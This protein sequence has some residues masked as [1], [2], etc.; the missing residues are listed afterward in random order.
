[1]LWPLLQLTP[2]GD[3]HAVIVLPG[4][5]AGDMSTLVMRQFLRSRGYGARGWGRGMNAGFRDNALEAV[6]SV[7]RELRAS[8]GRRVSLIG[9]SLG[10]TFARALASEHP[11]LVRGVIT[12]GTQYHG[13]PAHTRT[14][15]LYEALSGHSASLLTRL[16]EELAPC[17]VPITSIY[18]RGDPMTAWP[19]CLLEPGPEA[20]N[21]EVVSSHLG[22][23]N[24]PAVLAAVADRLAQPEGEWKPFEPA[25]SVLSHWV[26]A[27]PPLETQPTMRL[28][29]DAAHE[30]MQMR[31][32]SGR[33]PVEGNSQ[34]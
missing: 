7:L 17:P 24:H 14:W 33:A 6:T 26:Y 1:M 11:E 13:S 10:G 5:A 18:T 29:T 8:T 27:K 20:E 34:G 32:Q 23:G 4:L 16:Q 19:C 3:G 25:G 9:W 28:A 2:A 22:L 12:I 15:R 30:R 21:L 31:E